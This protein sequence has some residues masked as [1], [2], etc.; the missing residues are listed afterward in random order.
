[1]K[2]STSASPGGI[3]SGHD[4]NNPCG[5]KQAVDESFGDRVKHMGAAWYVEL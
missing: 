3:I 1:M 2:F 5:V 4:Y